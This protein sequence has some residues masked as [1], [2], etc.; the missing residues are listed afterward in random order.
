VQS[1]AVSLTDLSRTDQAHWARQLG[2]A[3]EGRSHE[4]RPFV[5]RLTRT[6][7]AR[8]VTPAKESALT[9]PAIHRDERRPTILR[10]QTH[11]TA[12]LS[13]NLIFRG[14]TVRGF[15]WPCDRAFSAAPDR[16]GHRS[17]RGCGHVG[18]GC[19]AALRCRA[20]SRAPPPAS[21]LGSPAN[22][23]EIATGPARPGRID[24]TWPPAGRSRR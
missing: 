16:A 21:R 15:G 10:L 4:L 24:C 17:A 22:A 2:D 11:N 5:I 13:P 7:L 1:V 18:G 20:H 3:N 14:R 8:G 19:S 6:T 12:H 23:L 9:V